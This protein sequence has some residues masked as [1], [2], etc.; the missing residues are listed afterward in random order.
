MR[1]QAAIGHEI[2]FD[3]LWDEADGPAQLDIGQAFLPQI[4]DGFETDME[5]LGDLFRRP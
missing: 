2:I 4:E 1:R 3:L 5:I